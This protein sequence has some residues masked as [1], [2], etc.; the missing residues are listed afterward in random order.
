MSWKRKVASKSLDILKYIF[1]Y[2]HVPR[3]I[4]RKFRTRE[5]TFRETYV[6]RCKNLINAHLS[7]FVAEIAAFGKDSSPA[8][9]SR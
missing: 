8:S 3:K 1:M 7:A 5:V 9:P 2:E 6:S 4:Q